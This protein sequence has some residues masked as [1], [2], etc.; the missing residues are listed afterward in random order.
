MNN[1]DENSNVHYGYIT[2]SIG[3]LEIS[4]YNDAIKSVEFVENV[5]HSESNIAIINNAKTQLIEY[6]NGKRKVF[7][8]KLALEGTEFQIRVWN[9]LINIPYGQT[10]SYGDIATA[11]GN[12][13][14]S[15]AVGGA[16][17]KN[18]I[19]IIVPC[20]RVIGANQKLVGY[21][22]GLWRKE[23]LLELENQHK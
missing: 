2:T 20:H 21:G 16:N 18:P 1:Q 17:N 13:K 9:A 12:S 7:N 22:G 11:I 3:L 6:F 4:A 15:R 14:A 23:G 8:L 5:S 10:V 19:A